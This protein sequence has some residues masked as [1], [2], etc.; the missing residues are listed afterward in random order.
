L[1]HIFDKF[2][3]GDAGATR[4]H[5]G[6]GLGLTI[7]RELVDMHGGTVEASSPGLGQGATFVVRLPLLSAGAATAP[8]AEQAASRPLA[9]TRVLVV[10]D[11]DDARRWLAAVLEKAG[12]TTVTA[13]SAAAA[14][15]AL[16]RAPVDA[17]V[18]DIGMPGTDGI[19][20]LEAI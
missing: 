16:A 12:A 7:V 4:R 10:D 17:I 9:E 2:R 20:L 3:Q 6:L 1:P 13:G 5:G 18:S 15:D 19:Q 8:D 11:D 14:L